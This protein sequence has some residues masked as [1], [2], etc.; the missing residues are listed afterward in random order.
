MWE[1]SPYLPRGLWWCDK[2]KEMTQTLSN[3]GVAARAAKDPKVI[4]AIMWEGSSY[5]TR[6]LW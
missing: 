2:T 4:R 5:L 1:G 6:G 3:L